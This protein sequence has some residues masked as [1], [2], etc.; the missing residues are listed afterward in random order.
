MLAAQVGLAGSVELGDDVWLGGQAG[1]ADHVRIGNGA[2][3]AAKSGVIADVPAHAVVAGFPAV[4]RWRWLRGI[5]FL[6]HATKRQ[7]SE[8]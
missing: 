6:A 7:R 4:P 2:R 3:I 1:V 5:A 8:E